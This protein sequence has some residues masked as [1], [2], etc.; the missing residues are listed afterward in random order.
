M[1]LLPPRERRRKKYI[2][3]GISLSALLM[4]FCL[5]PFN[6]EVARVSD[7]RR[8]DLEEKETVVAVMDRIEDRA[9]ELASWVHH[10][11]EQLLH[12]SSLVEFAGSVALVRTVEDNLV[13]SYLF[14]EADSVTQERSLVEAIVRRD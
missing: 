3:A 1:N 6:K 10:V 12:G 11:K 7:T 2:L 8:L 5:V 9:P 14:F 4:A 13:F